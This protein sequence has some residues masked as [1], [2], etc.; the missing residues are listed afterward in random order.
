MEPFELVGPYMVQYFDLPDKKILLF[1]EHHNVV[2]GSNIATI[3][4]W[5]TNR[6]YL[7]FHHYVCRVVREMQKSDRCLDLYLE[8][9]YYEGKKLTSAATKNTQLNL[10]GCLRRHFP[11]SWEYSGYLFYLRDIFAKTLTQQQNVRFHNFDLRDHLHD[12]DDEDIFV[13]PISD[14]L[15]RSYVASTPYTLVYNRIVKFLFTEEE[16]NDFMCPDEDSD[17]YIDWDSPLHQTY[18]IFYNDRKASEK[19][20]ADFLRQMKLSTPVKTLGDLKK[21]IRYFL[22]IE[23]DTESNRKYNKTLTLFYDIIEKFKVP[24]IENHQARMSPAHKGIKHEK[25]YQMV[26][27]EMIREKLL[28]INKQ[29]SKTPDPERVKNIAIDFLAER[30]DKLESKDG[31]HNQLWKL[32]II[33]LSILTDI[34]AFFR[35]VAEWAPDK[36]PVPGCD[37]YQKNIIHYAGSNH[38]E[39]IALLLS[40]Y[41]GISPQI[42]VDKQ[43]NPTVKIFS[44]KLVDRLMFRD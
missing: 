29:L 26:T 19:L 40:A 16:V 33:Y 4:K 44:P 41:Y 2:K 10:A 32:S 30:L 23:N 39:T 14:Y 24:I 12:K 7:W 18:M 15:F 25:Q 43:D 20:C 35:M 6:K 37:Q 11:K 31:I 8:D 13:D 17:L 1:G 3:K 21:W 28:I 5:Q 22:E 34:Y 27:L 38:T 42:L 36:H 9:N